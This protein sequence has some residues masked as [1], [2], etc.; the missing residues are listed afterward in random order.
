MKI[1][2]SI[3]SSILFIYYYIN[4]INLGFATQFT[5]KFATDYINK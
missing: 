5:L 3:V 1:P 4:L 2:T